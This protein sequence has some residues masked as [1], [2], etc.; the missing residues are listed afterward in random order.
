MVS[1][2]VPTLDR[3][4]GNGYPDGSSIL[5]V[6]QPGIGK[7]A[8]GYWFL[9][10]GLSQGDYCLYVTHRRVNDILTDIRGFGLASEKSPDWIAGAGSPTRCELKDLASISFNIK[11]VLEQNRSRR[12]RI[13]TDILSP[14]MVLNPSETMYNYWSQQ[15]EGVKRYD[16]VLL[17]LAERGMQMRTAI[18]SMEHLFDGV[19]E[20]KIYEDGLKLT[21]ILR[22]K[23][24]LGL[25][26]MQGY[27]TFS[28]V[29]SAM[30]IAP[31]AI[32]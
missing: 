16:G 31:G 17:A 6:G 22:I 8:L 4:L 7:E 19:I 9:H 23:K 24:M 29:R 30:E 21:P 25:P 1:T 27:F 12:I 5:V 26:P 10:S 3:I 20:M 28:F 11:K 14:L 13:V 2:G 32:V 15:I 18:T